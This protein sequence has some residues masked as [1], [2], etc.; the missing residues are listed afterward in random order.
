MMKTFKTRKFSKIRH[1]FIL[2]F[3]NGEFYDALH[4]EEKLG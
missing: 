2:A 3:A 4:K 1:I